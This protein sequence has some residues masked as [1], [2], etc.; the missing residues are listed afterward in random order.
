[1]QSN[2]VSFI[3]IDGAISSA[4]RDIICASTKSPTVKTIDGGESSI[5]RG[6]SNSIGNYTNWVTCPNR[7][8]TIEACGIEVFGIDRGGVHTI[9]QRGARQSAYRSRQ[10][11]TF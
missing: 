5:C 4:V 9:R 10:K 2:A 7:R 8:A 6:P 1:M 11:Q 3:Q